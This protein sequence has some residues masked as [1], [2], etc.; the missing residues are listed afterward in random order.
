[1]IIRKQFKFE[2]SHIVR[3]CSTKLCQ[4]NSHGHSYLVEIFF[5]S[6]GIDNGQMVMDFGL[7]KGTI[8]E[9]IES[10]DH[11]H[12]LWSKE[13]EEFKKFYYD[14]FERVI[15]LPCSPSAEMYSLMFFYVIDLIVKNTQ[16][17]NGE[18]EVE[19]RS[20]R[21]H[22]T[23]TGY[24]ESFRDDLE[25]WKWRLD[26]IKISDGIKV[27]WKEPKMWHYLQI[28]HKFINPDVDLRYQD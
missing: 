5:T 23:T 17:R 12:T 13:K 16:F 19:L 7:M 18:K 6:K 25:H 28:G 10:F 4:K 20:V 24:A 1:M 21:V 2:G 3:D 9:F 14:H 8:K 22:E 15:E 11:A 27:D 26:D